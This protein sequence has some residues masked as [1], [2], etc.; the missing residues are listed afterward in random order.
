MKHFLF[1]PLFLFFLNTL[2]GHNGSIRGSILEASTRAPLAG[3]AVTL[4]GSTGAQTYTD[5][6]GFYQFGSL[7]AGRYEL[8]IR[9]LGYQGAIEQVDVRTD[10]TSVVSTS[11]EVEPITL[12]NVDISPD[13]DISRQTVQALD[14]SLR[15]VVTSQDILRMV[16]GLFIAQHAGGGKAEQIFLRGFDIDHGTDIALQVDGIPVNM[17]S[18]AHGQGYAD[19]HFL[20]PETVNRVEFAKGP[21]YAGYGNLAT[22]GHVGF[23][24]KSALEKNFLA[25]QAGQFN[26][27]RLAG[28]LNLLG[29]PNGPRTQNAYLVTEYFFSDG[30]FDS[31][32]AYNRFSTFLKFNTAVDANNYL[33]ASLSAFTSRWDA[34]G[35]VPDRAVQTGQIGRFGSIDNTEGGNTSRANLNIALSSLLQDGS[36]LKSRFFYSNYTF[37]LYSNFTFFLHDPLNGDQIRQQEKRNLIGYSGSYTRTD[38]IGGSTWQ[39][40]A[41]V[42][43]RYDA[44]HDNELSHTVGRKTI[45]ERRAFGDLNES[46]VAVYFDEKIQIGRFFSVNPGLRFDQFHFLYVDKLQANHDRRIETARLASP[47]LNAYFTPD[48]RVQVFALSGYGFHSNDTRAVVAQNGRNIL[49]QALGYELGTTVKVLPSLLATIS[50]WRLHLEQEFVYVGDEAVVEAGGK[51]TRQGFDLALRWQPVPWL[52]ADADLNYAHGRSDD[53]PEGQNLIPLAAAW[54][55]IGGLTFQLNN[56]LNGSLRYRSIG[57]RPANENY[58]VTAP[59]YFLAD[60]VLNYTRPQFEVGITVQNLFN[61]NWNEAQFDTESRLFDEQAPVSE[62]HFSPGT[63]LSAVLRLG[64]FF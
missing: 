7:P 19:L 40:E 10:E 6:L 35:Q 43:F 3:V 42:Q 54:T 25:M 5:E 56:G 50:L 24:T 23:Q 16:P 20:I 36:L 55:S 26:T 32:Q 41:G 53:D 33:T 2:S 59:G 21:Y 58:S 48:D 30:Y 45:L 29:K 18:H 62:I 22:A 57:D 39:T 15:P 8:N 34:S 47:K 61:R 13:P 37:E 44:S 4:K 12:Q 64:V 27:Y 14:I 9:Y 60:L 49:P 46:N 17:V 1:F 38:R 28:G 11:L 31:P 51:T 63:P 52:F